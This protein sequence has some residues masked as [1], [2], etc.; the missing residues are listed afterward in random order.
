MELELDAQIIKIDAKNIRP[1]RHS[2]L[3]KGKDYSTTSYL[4]DNEKETFHLACLL[5]DR[6]VTCATFYPQKTGKIRAE[7]SFRLRGMATDS[8]FKRQGFG[9]KLMK[10]SF[11]LLKEKGADFLWCNARFIAVS[12]YESLGFK[13]SGEVFDIEGIGPHYYMFK[14]I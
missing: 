1:L 9:A 5:D 3:R 4:K 14:E 12:F 10:E 6:I 2:E 7:N 11:I 8:G 13:I